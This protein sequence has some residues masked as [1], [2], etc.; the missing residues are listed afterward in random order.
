MDSCENYFLQEFILWI[1]F[2]FFNI[3]IFLNL[4]NQV[5]KM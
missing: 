1:F 4:W 3:Y 2:F 5:E